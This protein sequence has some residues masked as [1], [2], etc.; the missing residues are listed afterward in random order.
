MSFFAEEAVLGLVLVFVL[1]LSLLGGFWVGT[2]LG[3]LF[4]HVDSWLG[5]CWLHISILFRL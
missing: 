3:R 1:H 5:L 4:L 2:I